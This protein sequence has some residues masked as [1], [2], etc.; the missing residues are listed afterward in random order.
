MGPFTTG[1]PKKGK[2]DFKTFVGLLFASN[3][4]LKQI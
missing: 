1:V 4:Y 3:I 2:N